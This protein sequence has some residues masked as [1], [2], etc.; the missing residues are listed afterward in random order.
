MTGGE[1]SDDDGNALASGFGKQLGHHRLRDID[2]VHLDP[3]RRQ[4]QD[5]PPRPDSEL[6][7]SPAPRQGGEKLRRFLG[8]RSRRV[9]EV[10]DGG[11][12]VAMG[13]RFVSLHA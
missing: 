11:D 7:R 3:P 2:A 8:I 6:E 5:D 4:G 1:I 10:V 13:C 9:Q 12:P